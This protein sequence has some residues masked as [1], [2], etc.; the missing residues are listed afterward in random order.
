VTV[1]VQVLKGLQLEGPLLLPPAA[2]LPPLARP[3]DT[4]EWS[5]LTTLAQQY[6]L[7]P[8]PVAPVQVIGSAPTINEAAV[9][10]FQR[11]ATLFNMSLEEVRNRVTITG[12]VEIGRLPGIV[13]VSLQVPLCILEEIGLAS[14]VTHQYT[15]PY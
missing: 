15:L 7:E 6:G 8:E 10:G 5:H 13:Q 1:R 14:I 12:G 9:N 2:Q 4:T 11:A 3:W